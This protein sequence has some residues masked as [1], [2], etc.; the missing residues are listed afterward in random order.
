MADDH[1]R[2]IDTEARNALKPLGLT[3]KGKSRVWLDDHGWWLIQ[4]EFQPSAWSRG[5]YLNIGINWMLYEGSVGAFNVGSRVDVP[6]VSATG[7]ENFTEDAR[8]LALR[9]K[10]EVEKAR[11]KFNT[12]GAAVSHYAHSENRSIWDTYFYGV[13]LGL[14]GDIAPSKEAFRAVTKHRIEFGWEKGLSQRALELSALVANQS[15]F[16]QTIRGVVARTRSIGNLPDWDS[17]LEFK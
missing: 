3:Q 8:H 10:R 16:V 6:F 2:V 11:A 15:A 17:D 14:A 13:L 12:L 5:S 1:N 7:N 4:V 9:A